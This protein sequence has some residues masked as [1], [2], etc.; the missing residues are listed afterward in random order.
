MGLLQGAAPRM[1]TIGDDIEVNGQTVYAIVDGFGAFT[2]MGSRYLIDE[3]IGRPDETGVV[4]IE[5]EQWYP[6]RAWLRA[7]DRIGREMG[8][9]ALMLIGKKIPSNAI[10]PPWVV[11]VDS[12]IKSVD[13]AYHL[14]HRKN[15][16]V[17]FAP[18]TGAML[19]GIGHYGYQRG[20]PTERLIL[21]VCD[22]P[23]P[24]AFDMGILIS[25]AH[26]FVRSARV[27]HA[28]AAPCRKNGDGHCTY[29]ITW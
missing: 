8:D 22:N 25:M 10:F 28:P 9:A 19:E 12:A 23:Y 21:S 15:G 18:E 11:D 3:G 6:Q 2:V 20:S 29:R 14:N 16:A 17:M 7:F 26:R 24:C 4:R 27:E 1:G 5:R 13:V